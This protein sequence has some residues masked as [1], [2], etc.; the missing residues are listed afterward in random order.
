MC[1][2]VYLI[3][4]IDDAMT[5]E[6]K[7]LNKNYIYFKLCLVFLTGSIVL[8]YKVANKTKREKKSELEYNYQSLFYDKSQ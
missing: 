5:I 6:K 8:I 2:C 1:V 7:K 3:F 4:N